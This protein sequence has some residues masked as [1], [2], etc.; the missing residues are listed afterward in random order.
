MDTRNDIYELDEDNN[1]LSVLLDVQETS[2]SDVAVQDVHFSQTQVAFAEG[3]RMLS[4]LI[5]QFLQSLRL[6][7]K[8]KP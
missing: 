8:E 7:E 5:N 4:F 1:I 6:N 3:E 2:S